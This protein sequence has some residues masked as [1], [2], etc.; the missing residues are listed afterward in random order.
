MATSPT[1]TK[2][3]TVTR[4][5]AA[6][7]SA[8]E[9][10]PGADDDADPAP[11]STPAEAAAEP[12][13][14]DDRAPPAPVLHRG[15]VKRAE[16]AKR[17][18]ELRDEQNKKAA[19]EAAAEPQDE[20]AAE[21]APTPAAPATSGAPQSQ[22][23]AAAAE[24][25]TLIV[26]GKPV[27]MS[28]DEIRRHAQIAIA[29]DNRLEESKRILRE[30]QETAQRLRGQ[31]S[32]HQPGTGESTQATPDP[33][34]SAPAEHQPPAVDR[35]KLKAL[36][37]RIQVGD[38]DDGADAL[39]EYGELMRSSNPAKAGLEEERVRSII[40]QEQT[41]TEIN[42]A[43]KGFT[44]DNQDLVADPLLRDASMTAIRFEMLKDLQSAGVSESALK[45]IAGD[46]ERLAKEYR[47]LRQVGTPGLRTYTEVMSAGAKTIRD[48]FGIKPPG[49]APDPSPSP[50]PPARPAP[51]G[52]SATEQRLDR[53][54]AQPSQPRSA[55]V[56]GVVT[57]PTR[58]KTPAEIIAEKRAARGFQSNR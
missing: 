15:D 38:T 35:N 32:E 28:L 39:H 58:P 22:A 21:P 23:P 46:A 1:D 52:P 7:A 16:A 42:D 33:V 24:K 34:Q 40:V 41:N 18:Q 48:K 30:A 31:G 56:R 37:E 57:P 6:T 14:A 17:Y 26:D 53:K 8:A 5:S 29:S 9:V 36:V 11:S 47:R 54:R 27:A 20:G 25:H 3:D 13:A 55:G 10:L 43:I 4:E 51:T 12:A 2:T 45:P 44:K 49:A 50:S 19:P